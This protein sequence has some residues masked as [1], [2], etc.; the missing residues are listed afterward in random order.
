MMM[1]LQRLCIFLRIDGVLGLR[2][3]C[4]EDILMVRLVGA[5][6]LLALWSAVMTVVIL[7]VIGD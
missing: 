2:W 1:Q 5:V 4:A 3:L 7:G 6:A